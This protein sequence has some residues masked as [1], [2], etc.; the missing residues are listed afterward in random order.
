MAGCTSNSTRKGLCG[1]HGSGKRGVRAWAIGDEVLGYYR[2]ERTLKYP[3]V[4][5]K[6]NANGSYRIQFDDG[7]VDTAVKNEDIFVKGGA[8]R[9]LAATAALRGGVPGASVAAPTGVAAASKKGGAAGGAKIGQPLSRILA[10]AKKHTADAKQS[11]V[12]GAARAVGG[13]GGGGG[14]GGA[15]VAAPRASTRRR[16]LHPAVDKIDG[17]RENYDDDG[18]GF[19]E[20]RTHWTAK[21][22]NPQTEWRTKKEIQ[23][24]YEKGAGSDV[25][26]MMWRVLQANGVDES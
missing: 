14:G 25:L 22:G 11:G 12:A 10:A 26:K 5:A 2:G 24:D 1:K 16:L 8:D 3:G 9:S 7:D 15:A 18:Y 21:S 23:D 13:G 17:W 4:I 20:F 6:R 19:E